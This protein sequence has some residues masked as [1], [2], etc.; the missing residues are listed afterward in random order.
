M[1]NLGPEGVCPCRACLTA[2]G[3][4]DDHIGI[5]WMVVCQIC[6]NKRCP[7]GN[8]HHNACTNSNA[9]G[10]KGSDWECVK[11]WGETE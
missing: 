11:P 7:H 2:S 1:I 10:Q 4:K 3:L 8:D 6:G 5:W 9:V